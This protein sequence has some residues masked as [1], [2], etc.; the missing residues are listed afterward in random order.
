[1]R[2]APRRRIMA[3]TEL[4]AL[5]ILTRTFIVHNSRSR[6]GLAGGY[7]GALTGRFEQ[8]SPETGHVVPGRAAFRDTRVGKGWPPKQSGAGHDTRVECQSTPE[9]AG[10]LTV[11]TPHLGERK[12]NRS[13]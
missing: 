9:K 5:T 13:N 11:H 8:R 10:A 2:L 1:M 12:T 6:M 3:Q 4:K 7:T